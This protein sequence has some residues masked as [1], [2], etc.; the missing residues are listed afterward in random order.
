MKTFEVN[1]V[2][3][4]TLELIEDDAELIQNIKHLI[5]ERLGEWFLNLDHG[6]RREVFE[7]KKFSEKQIMQAVYDAIY[8]EPRIIEIIKVDYRFDR[9]KRLLHM[10]LRLRTEDGEVGGDIDV[11]IRRLQ[12]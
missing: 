8:Q 2:G 3:D 1:G 11:D 7:E 12:A 4:W 6:F 9:I 10:S 5:Y